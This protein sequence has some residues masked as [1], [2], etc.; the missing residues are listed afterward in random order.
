MH[1]ADAAVETCL[2]AL[3]RDDKGRRVAAD[4]LD[5]FRTFHM[6]LLVPTRPVPG[7]DAACEADP[8]LADARDRLFALPPAVRRAVVLVLVEGFSSDEAAAILRVNSRRLE[9]LLME[10]RRA[11]VTLRHTLR[12]M[13]IED[14]QLIGLDIAASLKEMGYGDCIHA[15]NSTE[16]FEA[17]ADGEP[18]LI[19]ADVR[20]GNGDS[21]VELA[22]RLTGRRNTPVLYVTAFPEIPLAYPGV[23][24]DRVLSKPFSTSAFKAMVRRTMTI[25]VA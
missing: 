16:A 2:K 5:L 1:A 4:D 24:S 20:L 6:T 11:L 7:P 3:R 21:G 12:A 17:A 10:G 14:D 9:R 25:P 19:I 18:D 22:R 15:A 23:S 13:I 8:Q